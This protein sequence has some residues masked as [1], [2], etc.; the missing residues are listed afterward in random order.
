MSVKAYELN[1]NSYKIGGVPKYLL[2][3][4]K[5]QGRTSIEPR[6]YQPKKGLH[7]LDHS[8]RN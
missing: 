8:K 5:S 3:K 4:I 7:L 6:V 2:E 1:M